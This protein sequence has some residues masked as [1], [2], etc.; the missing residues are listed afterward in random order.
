MDCHMILGLEEANRCYWKGQALKDKCG[1]AGYFMGLYDWCTHVPM[2][3]NDSSKVSQVGACY[4]CCPISM[5]L[6]D[7]WWE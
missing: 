6:G 7:P 3:N 2:E 5:Q 1:S 4:Q